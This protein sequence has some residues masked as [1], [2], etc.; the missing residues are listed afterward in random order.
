MFHHHALIEFD[1]NNK[2]FLWILILIIF[3]GIHFG[4]H[5]FSREMA[6]PQ[7]ELTTANITK[8]HSP[9]IV[10]EMVGYTFKSY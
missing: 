5:N 2:M 1:Y 6:L 10:D 9:S 7:K 4:W 3:F 8:R